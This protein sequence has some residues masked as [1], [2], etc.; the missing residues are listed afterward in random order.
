[1]EL[2]EAEDELID[3]DMDEDMK[4]MIRKAQATRKRK[5][6]QQAAL[7]AQTTVAA[8]AAA[9]THHCLDTNNVRYFLSFR[10]NWS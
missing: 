4:A 8:T 5:R 7:A 6:E 1:M 2:T 10:P 9:A 3:D